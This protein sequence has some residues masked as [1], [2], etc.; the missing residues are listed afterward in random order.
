MDL[1]GIGFGELLLILIVTL[2]V[3]G[4]GKLPEIGR[5]IGRMTRNLKRMSS[6]FTAAMNSE[7][8]REDKPRDTE[9]ERANNDIQARNPP[10]VNPGDTVRPGTTTES[11]G[12]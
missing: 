7:I 12:T 8:S 11:E 10:Q 1:F 3:F 6:E 5:T 2:I 4:P 9:G